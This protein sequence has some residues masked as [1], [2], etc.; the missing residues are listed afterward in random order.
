MLIVLR[1]LLEL[2]LVVREASVH[3]EVPAA[4]PTDGRDE[5][6]GRRPSDVALTARQRGTGTSGAPFAYLRQVTHQSVPS[7][8]YRCCCCVI[9]WG[10]W[11]GAEYS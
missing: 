10:T 9:G 4:G 6:H 3:A 5:C 11:S 1:E 7:A 2:V 8:R